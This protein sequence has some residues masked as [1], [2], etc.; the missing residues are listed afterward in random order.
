MW[1]GKFIVIEGGDGTGKAT[2]SELLV[3]RLKQSREFAGDAEVH[4][5]SFPNY[6]SYWGR[7]VS[8]YLSGEFGDV[9]SSGP[10]FPALLFALDR[11]AEGERMREVLSQ[12]GWIVADRYSQSNLAHQG[13]KIEDEEERDEFYDWLQDVEYNGLNMLVP[14]IV[15]VLELDGDIEERRL[16]QRNKDSSGRDIHE[17]DRTYAQKVNAEYSR[18]ARKYGWHIVRCADEAGRELSREEISDKIFDIVQKEVG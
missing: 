2:Q 17:E 1:D 15:I 13:V 6:D 5:W 10:Y 18:L 12:G 9:A 16:A 8:K 14:D 11:S 7:Q 3:E 4:L